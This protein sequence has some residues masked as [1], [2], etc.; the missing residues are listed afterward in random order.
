MDPRNLKACETITLVEAVRADGESQDTAPSR[1]RVKLIKAGISA[2]GNDYPIAVLHEAAP[3]Y[4]GARILVRGDDEHLADRGK[5]PRNIGGWMRDVQRVPDGLEATMHI[6]EAQ[7]WLKTMMWDGWKNGMKDLVGL[8]HV[9]EASG[10]PHGG[11]R[12]GARVT[13]IRKVNF[14]DVVI[15]P[16]AG[17]EIVSLAESVDDG[18]SWIM[19]KE[20]L[21]KLIEAIAPDRFKAIDK[22]AVTDA[23]L[24]AI[25]EAI[26][27][28]SARKP[29]A[30]AGDQ[31][32]SQ[33]VLQLQEAMNGFKTS[34]TQMAADAAN[35]IARDKSVRLAEAMFDGSGLPAAALD[36]VRDK[37]GATAK[38]ATRDEIKAIITAEAQYLGTSQGW[39]GPGSSGTG[40]TVTR[41]QRDKFQ[42]ALDG[43][44]ANER[45]VKL[46]ESQGDTMP[47]Y[48]SLREAY[49]DFTGD[50]HVTGELRNC[51]RLAEAA[52]QTSDFQTAITTGQALMFGGA[53][54]DSIRRKL[55]ADFRKQTALQ[56][57]RMIAD[58]VPVNDF[59]Y[60][61]RPQIGGFG[62]L[63]VV[64]ET[65]AYQNFTATPD[66]YSPYYKAQKRGAVQILTLEMI[67]ND[68]VA[69]LQRF[70]RLMTGAAL[71]TLNA[72]AFGLITANPNYTADGVAL[73]HGSHANLG[74]SA[75]SMDAVTAGR[76][77][78]RKQTEANSSERLGLEAKFLM[79]PADLE[80]QAFELC[81]A[82]GQPVLLTAAAAGGVQDSATRPN[83][84]RK[85]GLEPMVFPHDTS[86]TDNWFIAGDKDACPILEIGFLGGNEEP[87]IF[88]QDQPTN[89]S[90]FSNDQI[91]YK[92]RHIYGGAPIEYRNL[93]GS[94]VP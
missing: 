10:T 38:P 5:N 71:R 46:S 45:V 3:L 29:A 40:V 75:L 86:D 22:D 81:Y 84:L 24:L 17:G 53:L 13:K 89:G 52:L 56:P 80:Q 70:P 47:A 8:S 61:F 41:D 34:I 82:T 16:S 85:I 59:R 92:I 93:F 20:K 44:V 33:V 77:A 7:A 42:A 74:T 76:L 54:G 37:V 23:D 72:F 36:R 15:N 30:E 50:Q 79:V 68:D 64:N 58:V 39:K 62:D 4:E 26:T 18:G 91:T 49:I 65:G 31:G 35:E 43:L 14:V 90:M 87:D 1:Y 60:N 2:N 66:D 67:V 94:I 21:L 9:A 12:R 55:Q 69:M 63:A 28:D 11:G 6:S 88:I 83:F 48:R 27:A 19:D 57:W 32:A 51:T 73:F 78:M 25:V